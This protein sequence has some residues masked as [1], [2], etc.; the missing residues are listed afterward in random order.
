MKI[1]RTSIFSLLA[2]TLSVFL[3]KAQNPNPDELREIYKSC[4]GADAV[5]FELDEAYVFLP[6]VFVPLGDSLNS[7]FRPFIN[8]EVAEIVDFTI[9]NAAGDSII[10]Y[11]PTF[12]YEEMPV[13]SW[14]G[15][16]EDGTPYQG[17]FRYGMRLISRKGA[18]RIVEGSACRIVCTPNITSAFTGKDACFFPVQ[19]DDRQK[20]LDRAKPNLF[21]DC[22]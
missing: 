8:G 16:R 9:L 6:N 10:F 11:R 3:V 18:L 17:L 15:L 12:N 5:E 14:N 21:K 1:V 22:N 19:F 20:R 2:F 7:T 13:Y 4:C